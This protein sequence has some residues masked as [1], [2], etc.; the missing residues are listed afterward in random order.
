MSH[1]AY[2]ATYRVE[3]RMQIQDA[4]YRWAR[5]VDR[6]EWH[7][8]PT[9]FH[10]DAFD[11]HGMYRGDVPGLL[12]WMRERHR[13]ISQSMHHIGNVLIEFTG[14][15]SAIVESYVIAYQRYLPAADGNRTSRIAALGPRLGALD[16]PIDAVV[17]AR[18]GDNFEK[19]KDL[20]RIAKRITVFEGRYLTAAGPDAL[21]D[22][23][24]VAAA[25]DE[26][27][28]ILVARRAAGL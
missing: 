13:F 19:R 5:L 6:R 11:E 4:I 14:P 25:R 7:L 17:N 2:S 28:P 23:G 3:D 26:S 16:D 8:A 20:W 22:S 18:Y 21:L 9:V 15:T 1:A 24:W 12:A 27:D 10:N